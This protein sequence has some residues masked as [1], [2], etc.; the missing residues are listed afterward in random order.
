MSLNAPIP[1]I[2]PFAESG[3][4]NA[5][6]QNAD[7]ATGNAGFDVGFPPVT[8]L[9]KTAGGIPP[10]GQDFNGILFDITE[11]LQYLQSGKPYAFNQD[12]A[13]AIGG[14]GKGSRVLDP[15]DKNTIWSSLIDSNTGTPS[16]ANNWIKSGLIAS[17]SE[18]GQT[19]YATQS[20]INSGLSDDVSITPKKLAEYF[21]RSWLDVKA[22]RLPNTT[23]IADKNVEISII[24]NCTQGFSLRIDGIDVSTFD[25]AGAIGSGGAK[26][27]STLYATASKGQSIY[28]YRFNASDTITKW[29]ERSK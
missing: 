1:F 11:A 18:Y 24:V 6:P 13:V 9:P 2:K 15:S 8:M 14:Y 29:M 16:S 5:I 21:N 19:K 23:Y 7:I 12:F 26:M 27:S 4:K 3:A 10:W 25:P 20:E 17:E 28:L 22:Q